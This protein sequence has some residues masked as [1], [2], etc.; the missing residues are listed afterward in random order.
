L[1]I[2]L[3]REKEA[4]VQVEARLKELGIELPEPVNPVA[5]YVRYVQ[6]GNLLLISGTGPSDAVPKGKLG[7]D[8]TIEQG[9]AV[10]RDVG[11]QIISTIKAALGDLDRVERVLKVLG[12]VNAA[13][14]FADHPKVINGCSNLLV[15]VFG[16]KGRHTRSAVGFGSLP[17]NIAVE[18]E[19]MVQ[20]S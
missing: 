12:M 5:T 6:T 20:V 18:I 4:S 13:P 1:D 10:A 2:L 15:E 14:D 9:Q 16:E 11:L 8:L 3:V 19:C 17:S 7:I